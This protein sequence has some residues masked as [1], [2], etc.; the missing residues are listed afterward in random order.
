MF[1]SSF[2]TLDGVTSDVSLNTVFNSGSEII[3]GDQRIAKE[4][5]ERKKR[6]KE[7]EEESRKKMA[8]DYKKRERKNLEEYNIHLNTQILKY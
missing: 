8:D 7:K 6:E 2:A 5:K 3:W 4:D 1:S